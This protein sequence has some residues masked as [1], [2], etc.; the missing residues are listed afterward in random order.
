[1]G[2]GSFHTHTKGPHLSFALTLNTKDGA[3][4]VL[5]YCID[6]GIVAPTHR[7]CFLRN[8]AIATVI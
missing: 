4:Y 8:L 5:L 7:V 2:G 1:M 6:A 3:D